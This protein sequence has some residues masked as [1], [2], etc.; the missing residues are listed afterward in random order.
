MKKIEQRMKGE[1]KGGKN[2]NNKQKMTN[3]IW[4]RTTTGGFAQRAQ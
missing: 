1:G 2:E 4:K 3:E